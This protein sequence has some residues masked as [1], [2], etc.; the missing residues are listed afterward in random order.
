ME[1]FAAAQT[2]RGAVRRLLTVTFAV[3]CG[4]G[5]TLAA[6]PAARAQAYSTWVVGHITRVSFGTGA[7]LIM[8]DNGPPAN[9]AGV[10]Y[11]WLAV[12][13]SSTVMAAFVTGLWMRGDAPQKQL[14]IYT[15]ALDSSGN[16][17]VNQ[18]DTGTSG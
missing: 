17:W 6:P 14:V 12:S 8:V 9:C 15:N 16:C 11:G 10:A 7:V 13:Q 5:A 2:M 1:G 4:L 18:I 3:L